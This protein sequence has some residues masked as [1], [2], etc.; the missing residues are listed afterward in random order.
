MTGNPFGGA[1]HGIGDSGIAAGGVEKNLAGAKLTG[2][3][4]LG[5]DVGGSAVFD[6][7][8]GV[9]P[10][11]FAQKGYARQVASERIE[12]EQRGISDAFDETVAKGFTQSWSD[13]PKFRVLPG[14]ENRGGF[15][16]TVCHV[17]LDLRDQR[18]VLCGR[19]HDM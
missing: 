6:G 14:D 4:G 8:A 13:F 15:G 16:G 17:E 9:I 12:A 11:R 19:K 5:D 1:E 7:S 3:A 18:N 10:F 2:A